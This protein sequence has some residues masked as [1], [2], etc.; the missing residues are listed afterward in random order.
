M[1]GTDLSVGP[2]LVAEEQHVM[3][4]SYRLAVED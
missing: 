2:K 3:V 4:A 1:T